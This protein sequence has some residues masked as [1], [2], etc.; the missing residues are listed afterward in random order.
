MSVITV[1]Y[2][3][4]STIESTIRSVLALQYPNIE[5][6]IIDGGSTDGTLDIIKKYEHEIDFWQSEPDRGIYDGMNKGVAAAS[7]TWINFMNSGDCF[8]SSSALDFF[9]RFEGQA[10]I[11]YGNALIQYPGFL[12]PF[13]IAPLN[14]SWKRMPICH[15]AV[16]TKR[17]VMEHYRFDLR[18]RLSSDF[19]F[20]Y[21]AWLDG[22]KFYRVDVLI[23]I[24]DF[25]DG[26]SI[27]NVFRSVKER[28]QIVMR[29]SFSVTKWIYHT[30][31]NLYIY[32]AYYVKRIAG[33]R[34]TDLIIRNFF[35]HQEDYR[36]V[37]TM[38]DGG[39]DRP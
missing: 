34:I 28:K 6:V 35:G 4:A 3:A 24:F 2:N 37:K 1:S 19:N 30:F 33:R 13:E 26:A 31:A 15:Q 22:K 38:R 10:D 11:I 25:T 27:K 14:Q 9:E 32:L 7:G 17:S 16:F 39:P 23:C 21:K 8:A 36:D 20:I 18:Y 5:Y 29:E 12:T